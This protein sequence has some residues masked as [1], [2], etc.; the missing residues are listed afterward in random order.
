MQT[1]NTMNSEIE[2]TIGARMLTPEEIEREVGRARQLRSRLLGQLARDA[3]DGIAA[4][5][6]GSHRASHA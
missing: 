1:Q 6:R 3:V 2:T 5:F 4:L